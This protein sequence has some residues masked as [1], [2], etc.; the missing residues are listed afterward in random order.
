MFSYFNYILLYVSCICYRVDSPTR[1]FLDRSISSRMGLWVVF[2]ITEFLMQ[3]SVDQDQTPHSAASDLGLHCLP[4][5]LLWDA[6]EAFKWLNVAFNK[7]VI[8][9]FGLSSPQCL[10]PLGK[11]LSYCFPEN[12][13]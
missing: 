10:A 5:S 12:R 7:E 3:N 9:G 2:I 1:T 4:M 13:I 11:I 6:R 8:S